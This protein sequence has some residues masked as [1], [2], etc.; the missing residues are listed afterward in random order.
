[1]PGSEDALHQHGF[2]RLPQQEA[3]APWPA[4][5]V[6]A[7]LLVAQTGPLRKRAVRRGSGGGSADLQAQTER[8][9]Q[10]NLPAPAWVFK[11]RGFR[12]GLQ[13][14]RYEHQMTAFPHPID[15]LLATARTP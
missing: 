9:R 12:G 3:R 13:P 15:E 4:R 11:A 1:M 2:G 5:P 10:G 6:L 8:L 14:W 7:R